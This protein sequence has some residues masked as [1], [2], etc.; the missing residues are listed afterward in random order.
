LHNTD[1]KQ[2]IVVYAV[3]HY[4]SSGK[5][6]KKFLFEPITIKPWSSKEINILPPKE[7]E[8]FGANLIVRWKADQPANPPLVEVM[9]VGQ[10]MNRGVSLLTQGQ[11]IKE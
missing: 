6:L 11:E 9:M 7:L 1:P 8:E 10:V 4:D 5:L 2:V 3:D